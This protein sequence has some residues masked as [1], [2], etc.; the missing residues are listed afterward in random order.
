MLVNDTV[1]ARVRGLDSS[2]NPKQI[3]LVTWHSENPAIA[4]IDED[5]LVHGLSLG[6]TRIVASADGITQTSALTVAGI[7]HD[8]SIRTDQTWTLGDAPHVVRGRLQVGAPGGVTLTI[9]PGVEILFRQGAALDFGMGGPG[10][11]STSG[12]GEVITMRAESDTASPGHWVGLTFRSESHGDLRNVKLSRCGETTGDGAGACIVLR[13]WG[14]IGPPAPTLLVD[15][16]TV[17]YAAAGGVL[18]EGKSRFAPGSKNLTVVNSIGYAASVTAGALDHFPYGGSFSGNTVSEIQVSGDT[19]EASATLRDVGLIWRILEPVF[20]QGPQAPVLT[21]GP[22][23]RAR[24]EYASGMIIGEGYPAGLV[25]GEPGGAMVHLE[26][27]HEHGW[28]GIMLREHAIGSSMT[29][30]GLRR[31]DGCIELIG[32]MSGN[33]PAPALQSVA[34]HDAAWIGIVVVRGARIGQ[35]SSNLSVDGNA[36]LP[37]GDRCQCHRIHPNGELHRQR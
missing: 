18:L 29:N 27:A 15:G 12:T 25:V 20:V 31:C 10:T 22:G 17:E 16:V 32:D 9:E 5:G 4:S 8:D 2:G 36:R 28:S 35:G 23:V 6:S 3:G 33:G 21:I 7:L 11:F 13:N 14:G 30:V 34:I 24:F 37:N 1:R 26:E 19:L